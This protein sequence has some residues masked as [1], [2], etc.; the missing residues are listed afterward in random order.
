M[1]SVYFIFLESMVISK[2]EKFMCRTGKTQ[3]RFNGNT[4]TTSEALYD[5]DSR[6]RMREVNTE[7]PPQ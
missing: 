7:T 2:L 6:E 3:N 4:N 1:S 5:G